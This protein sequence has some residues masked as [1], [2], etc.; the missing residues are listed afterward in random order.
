MGHRSSVCAVPQA[1]ASLESPAAEEEILGPTL[2]APGLGAHTE[3]VNMRGLPGVVA[4]SDRV[5][6]AVMGQLVPL[7]AAVLVGP[8][9]M[10]GLQLAQHVVPPYAGALQHLG[11]H[12]LLGDE[13][14]LD[15]RADARLVDAARSATPATVSS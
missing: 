14:R 6:E 1:S 4:R 10:G 3:R 7:G 5:D 9:E 11:P 15:P 2:V 12:P 8:N 13:P